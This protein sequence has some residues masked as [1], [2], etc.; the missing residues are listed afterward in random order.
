MQ[1]DERAAS[2]ILPTQTSSTPIYSGKMWT[3][4]IFSV[5]PAPV[6]STFLFTSNISVAL[7]AFAADS[8]S[9]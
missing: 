3:G 5:V 7:L 9:A 6:A 4:D 2:T 1:F 8:P